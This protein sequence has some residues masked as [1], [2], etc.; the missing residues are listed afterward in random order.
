MTRATRS[1]RARATPL[2]PLPRL[3]RRAGSAPARSSSP[4]SAVL[5]AWTRE[6]PA[7]DTLKDY[8]PLVSTRVLGADGSEVFQFARER[9]TVVPFADI[10]DV[11]RKAV[12][13]AEDARFYEHEGVNYLAISRCAVKGILRGGIACGGSTITQQVV[14]TFLL[15]SDGR[16]KRK[17][18]ELVL[19]PRLE[20]NLTKDE[21]LYL[22]LNQIYPRPPP[23]RRRGGEPLLLRQE[24]PRPHPRRGRHARGHRPVPDAA[25]AGEPPC[26]A[27]RSGRSTCSGAWRRRASSRASRPRPRLRGAIVT[28]PPEPNPPGIWYADAVRRVLDER[29][30]AEAVETEGLPGRHR[31]GPRLCSATP[32][33]RSRRG[34]ARSTGARAGG[35][36]LAH[37]EP[38]Q[39]EAAMP[40]WRERLARLEPRV[41]RGAGVGPRL[42]EPGGDRARRGAP[43]GDVA[44]MARARRLEA[45]EVYAGLVTA[46]EEKSA[47]VD[48][49]NAKGTLS[50]ADVAWARKWN[51]TSATAAP[52]KMASVVAAGDVV[53]VR[54]MPGKLPAGARRARGQAARA[55]ARADAR[56][57]GR[58]RRHRPARPAACAR[59]SAATTSRPRSST[60]PR[61]R[62]ASRAA[63]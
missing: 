1:P 9:R 32:R 39:V 37:L 8:E 54:V 11:L 2:P 35:A 19:A 5:F 41:G 33:R 50:L 30:G 23:L 49:G 12:L 60:A 62:G 27:P 15:A 61:R 51:P 22:Y 3:L 43:S 57:A 34:C 52:R 44:R 7:F 13:A 56:G 47:T 21:I 38:E 14:K 53:L 42:R 63:R 16:L 18:K 10:P 25:L 17:V 46:V 26:S 58:A 59:S 40:L 4:A 36:P 24:R 31:D 28:H 29:Y 45:G 55:L 6:L 20:E 48:L